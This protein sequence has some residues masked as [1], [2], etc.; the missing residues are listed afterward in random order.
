MDN[1]KKDERIEDLEYVKG[2]KIMPRIQITFV[3]EWMRFFCPG[4]PAG[5]KKES[6]NV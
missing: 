1:I 3:L 6:E 5:K 4:S 2:L